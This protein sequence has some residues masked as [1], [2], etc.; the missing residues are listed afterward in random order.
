MRVVFDTNVLVS[1]LLFEDSLPAQAFFFAARESEI[2]ISSALVEEIQE[3]LNRPKFDRFMAKNHRE[4]FILSLVETA[5]LVEIRETVE[6]CRD[7]KD[8]MILEVAVSGN[9][10]IIVTGDKDLLVLQPFRGIQIL[11]PRSF[12]DSHLS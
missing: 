6:V 11:Q 7:P 5:T 8:N 2:I 1:A 12:L 4:N 10:E 9:A 3:V